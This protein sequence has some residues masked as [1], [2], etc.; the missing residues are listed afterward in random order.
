MFIYRSAGT[1]IALQSKVKTHWENSYRCHSQTQSL[2]VHSLWRVIV[3]VCVWWSTH[4]RSLAASFSKCKMLS[5][6]RAGRSGP[7]ATECY[8]H[9]HRKR[10]TAGRREV[11][12]PRGRRRES[13]ETKQRE[14]EGSI[15]QRHDNGRRAPSHHRRGDETPGVFMNVRD[16]LAPSAAHAQKYNKLSSSV[17]KLIY[18]TALMQMD[19]RHHDNQGQAKYRI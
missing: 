19:H 8:S 2:E 7:C 9:T 18:I 17:I 4:R 10:K 5:G 16:V 13:D 3:C 12:R 6:R 15:H 1:R 11:L 14:G